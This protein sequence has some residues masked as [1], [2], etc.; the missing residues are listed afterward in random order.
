MAPE[1]EFTRRKSYPSDLSREPFEQLRPQ[2]ESGRKRTRP[3]T[4]DCYE[5]FCDILYL[6]KGGISWRRLPGDFPPWRTVPE[7]FRIWSE[8]TLPERTSLLSKILA[9]LV[10]A[11]RQDQGRPTDT[12]MVI[13]DS[14]SVKHADTAM[15]QGYEAGK[16]VSRVKRHVTVDTPGP[17]QA[18]YLTTAN[19]TDRAGALEML[20]VAADRGPGVRTVL[21]DGGYPGESSA[22]SVSDLR[23]ATVEMVKRSELHQWVVLPTRW[24]V[25]RSFAWLDK[26]RRLWPNGERHLKTSLQMVVLAFLFLLLKRF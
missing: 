14:Q 19:V 23:E 6:L 21:A 24:V 25:E 3:R 16:T 4:V 26:Y 2:L 1:E 18:S 22:T 9:E 17:P 15:E 10:A 8:P 5:V 12:S 20:Q 13:I 11:V 7:Y